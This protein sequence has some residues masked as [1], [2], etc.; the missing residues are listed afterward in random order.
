M[1]AIAY[2]YLFYIHEDATNVCSWA[3]ATI[4]LQTPACVPHQAARSWLCL[5][6][7]CRVFYLCVR[8]PGKIHEEIKQ[9][10]MINNGSICM[11]QSIATSIDLNKSIWS[12]Y[13]YILA[14]VTPIDHELTSLESHSTM[15]TPPAHWAPQVVHLSGREAPVG[16]IW[17]KDLPDWFTQ[18]DLQLLLFNISFW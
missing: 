1:K 6:D 8:L 2:I 10:L 18:I 14:M 17:F 16:S 4:R 9:L 13:Q 5:P 11:N 3:K 12:N 7:Q 15:A